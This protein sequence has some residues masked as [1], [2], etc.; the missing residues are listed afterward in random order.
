MVDILR[1]AAEQGHFPDILEF[2]R[3]HKR[4][5]RK[6]LLL[7]SELY[8]DERMLKISGRGHGV[9][10][11]AFKAADLRGNTDVRLELSSGLASTRV[12]QTQMLLQLTEAGFF[13]AQ[14][15]LDPEFRDE[16]LRRMGL[17][18]FKDRLNVDVERAK[19][20]NQLIANTKEDGIIDA[21]ID[22]PV[23]DEHPSGMAKVP[24]I[25]QIF[26]TL[27]ATMEGT[28]AQVISDDP[29]FVYDNHAV[30]WEVHRKFILSNEF[31]ALPLLV[32]QIAM[33][34]ANEHKNMMN[35][36]LQEQQANM[37]VDAGGV[38]AAGPAVADV[39]QQIGQTEER[40]A[41]GPV[42]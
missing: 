6:R 16:L 31:Q 41:A 23:S 20:E 10:V 9:E 37:I 3:A 30:H 39:N 21:M 11:K 42:Q 22:V 19:N 18:G 25:G 8:T 2:Y 1:D 27:G 17:S 4:T 28:E 15:D 13:S 5:Y 33:A 12:G 40:A 29:L 14:S 26:L 34:H 38:P 32:Q 35:I 24:I 7:A 36:A